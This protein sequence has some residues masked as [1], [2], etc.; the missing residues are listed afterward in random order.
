MIMW[1][2]EKTKNDLLNVF[3]SFPE[4]IVLDVETTGFSAEKNRII[5][6]SGIKFGITDETLVEKERFDTYINPGVLLPEKITEVTGI[7]DALL[8]DKPFESAVFPKIRSF[9]GKTA[10]ICGHN[11]PFDLR[12]I[13]AMYERYGEEYAPIVV[14]DTL[15][16]ARD[17][18]DLCQSSNNKLCTLAQSLGVDYGLTFHNSIDDVIACSR[19][20]TVF[21][22]EYKEKEKNREQSLFNK[23]KVKVK[24]LRYWPGYRGRARIYIQTDCGDFYYDVLKKIWGKGQNNFYD[25]EMIDMEQL[26]ADSLKFANVTTEREFARF[27]G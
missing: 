15:E 6:F 8:A 3:S 7:T 24:S 12:F 13:T 22:K 10:A 23:T 5:Q 21:V 27:R 11:V 4:L 26:R 18:T 2:S 9:L 20:L 1:R 17:M 25:L 14:L 16:M 19:L